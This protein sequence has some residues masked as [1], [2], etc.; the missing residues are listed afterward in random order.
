MAAARPF[1]G[2][3][4]LWPGY[5]LLVS[6]G[7]SN[8]R[9]RHVAASLLYGLDGPLRIE[10]DGTWHQ[11][12]GALVG[13]EVAQALDSS[14][15]RVLVVHIDPDHEFWR[16]F[17]R[18]LQGRDFVSLPREAWQPQRLDAA[19]ARGDAAALQGWLASV[20]EPMGPGTP[21]DARVRETAQK[22]R[23]DMPERLDLSALAQHAG[24]SA[25]RLTHLFKA[26]TGVT[27]R[28]FLLHL[29]VERAL[30]SWQPGMTVAQLATAA[31]FYDQPHLVRTV[32]EMFDALPSSLLTTKNLRVVRAIGAHL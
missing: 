21:L 29:K 14:Q 22:L 19:L 1:T 17:A 25:S 24:L 20:A 9:H 10:I 32:R 7:L 12:E 2:V 31:G 13:P 27:L 3:I 28:R 23:A 8:R 11:V 15:G 30:H 18:G 6:D 5:W 4:F 26:E 16:P